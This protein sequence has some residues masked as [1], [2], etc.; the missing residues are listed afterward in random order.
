MT[1]AKA[2]EFEV[3]LA[4]HPKR[5]LHAAHSRALR[6]DVFVTELGAGG[7]LVDSRDKQAL[8]SISIRR[9]LSIN[10]R[11]SDRKTAATVGV[12]RSDP[13]L[14]GDGGQGRRSIPKNGIMI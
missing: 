8:K 3:R 6:Y 11:L 4:A 10:L 5:R 1:I 14:H 12:Y 9:F 7:P 13:P 2:A